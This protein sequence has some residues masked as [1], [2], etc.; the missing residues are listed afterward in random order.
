MMN[1]S[2]QIFILT[3][4]VNPYDVEDVYFLSPHLAIQQKE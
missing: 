3:I 1:I 4:L 2:V